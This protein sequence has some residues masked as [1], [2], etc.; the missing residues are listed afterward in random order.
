MA[1]LYAGTNGQ[2]PPPTIWIDIIDY[3]NLSDGTV[4]ESIINRGTAGG[5][6]TNW[7][8][9][10]TSKVYRTTDGGVFTGTNGNT[11]GIAWN[12]PNS[13]NKHQYF[14]GGTNGT[15]AIRIKFPGNIT[16]SFGGPFQSGQQPPTLNY[17]YIQFLNAWYFDWGTDDYRINKDPPPGTTN[18]WFNAIFTKNGTNQDMWAYGTNWANGARTGT[19]SQAVSGSIWILQGLNAEN[20]AVKRLLTFPY[21]LTSLQI[22][23]LNQWMT[24]MP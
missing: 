15:I 5:Y 3:T 1:G 16:D 21:A 18:A 6:F 8:L 22:S 12:A 9:Y 20:Y 19:V 4:L 13:T 24:A 7:G 2:I 10:A 23:N 14:V 11:T 17:A